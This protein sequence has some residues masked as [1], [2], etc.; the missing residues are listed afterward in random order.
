MS[1]VLL[2]AIVLELLTLCLPLAF[3]WILD[4]VLSAGDMQLMSVLGIGCIVIVFFQAL[5]QGLRGILISAIGASL[6]AQWNSNLFGQLLR[7][8]FQYFERREVGEIMSRFHSVHS[9]QQTLSV[10]FAD[11]VLDGL[12]VSI[13]LL[14]LA[15]YSVPMAMLVVGAV[16]IYG[17]VRWLAYRLLYRLN[18]ERL[19]HEAKQQ[20]LMLEA[21]RAI[22]SIKLAGAESQRHSRVN[23]AGLEIANLDARV[24]GIGASVNAFSRMIFGLL[25]ISLLWLGAWFAITENF[26]IGALVAF[27]SFADI[28]AQR[29]SNLI[30]HLSELRLLD[31]HAERISDVALETREDLGESRHASEMSSY[32]IQANGLSFRYRQDGPRAL[33]DVNFVI[34]AGEHVAIVGPSGSGKTT[35]AKLLMGLLVPESGS[36]RVNGMDIKDFGIGRFRALFGTVM[37]NDQLMSGSIADNISFFDPDASFNDVIEAAKAA[38]IHQDIN[39]LPMGYETPVGDLGAALSGGQKQRVILARALYR[40]P[41]ILLLDEATSHL[42]IQCERRVNAQ[43][44]ALKITRIVIAHRPETIAAADRVLEID[45]ARLS[46]K[47]FAMPK[48]NAGLPT[49]QAC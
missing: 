25:R 1:Q 37:Q 28:F 6:K 48:A 46:P 23:N 12:T 11:A 40:K 31:L 27:V 10:S 38:D 24:N 36:I 45:G 19:N 20:T 14:V 18:E 39:V 16:A 26:S 43:I 8:P 35:L 7:L 49:R 29:A 9:V 2:L 42:D 30:D 4:G 32:E 5:T 22:L 17:V 44:S 41:A 21:V 15:L 13:V 47:P 33:E 3:Q 34:R